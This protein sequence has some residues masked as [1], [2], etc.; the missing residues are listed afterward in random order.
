M[1]NDE[2]DWPKRPV[3]R[4]ESLQDDLEVKNTVT[5]NT[6]KV[7][8]NIEPMNKLFNYCSD[9]HKQ[10]RSVA[11]LL[12]ARKTLQQL[13]DERKEFSK[14]IS[15]TEKDPERQKSKLERHM[16][17]YKMTTERKSLTLDDLD[18]AESEIIQF[19]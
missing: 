17:K 18:I 8:D 9:W 15:Q 10:K 6:I 11:W 13:K 19:S 7:K 5:V 16:E 14:T 3:E 1:T 4:K 12:R 2:H